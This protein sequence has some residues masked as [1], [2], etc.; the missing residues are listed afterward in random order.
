MTIL[1]TV[2]LQVPDLSAPSPSIRINIGRS[3]I[4][5]GAGCTYEHISQVCRLVEVMFDKTKKKRRGR[6]T[7]YP[8]P[9]P[10]DA[11]PRYL[12]EEIQDYLADRARYGL[13]QNTMDA[14]ANTLKVLLAVA[15]DVPVDQIDHAVIRKF[16]DELRWW[17]ERAG[18]RNDL[19]DLTPTQVMA[20]GR[21]EAR[22]SGPATSSK[23]THLRHLNAFFN[24]LIPRTL[25]FS[26][27]TEFLSGL[28]DD[29]TSKTRFPLSE[30]NIAKVF[31]PDI[32]VPWAKGHAH[33]WWIPMIALYTGAR[34]DEIAQLRTADIVE[35]QG[36]L[37]FGF[38]VFEKE[39]QVPGM[40]AKNFKASSCQRI[41]PIAQPL[42]DAGFT[43]F[44]EEMRARGF[45][46]LFPNLKAGVKAGGNKLN[47]AGYSTGF[48]QQFGT[49]LRAN[50]ELRSGIATHAFRH[51][52][53][54]ALA[55][56]DVSPEIVASITGH[57]DGYAKSGNLGR[58]VRKNQSK[59]R[60]KQVEALAL[61]K[62]GI[63]L[64]AYTPNQFEEM[65]GPNGKQYP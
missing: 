54:S 19:K 60:P 24:A 3:S 42:L 53:S 15:G 26:P 5:F 27:T 65:L 61:F 49:Y 13:K 43:A 11:A 25:K 16:W 62:P 36:S 48:I 20:V 34:V 63:E 44:V 55:D 64:P 10:L 58:Y 22:E 8:E 12:T 40:R 17:P 51:T 28:K 57:Q 29:K 18:S 35:D 39:A 23:K 1:K 7:R 2:S 56:E 52:L 41:I 14:Y 4:E 21:R 30:D 38:T 59:L 50:T 37:C 6:T 46:R 47:G 31:D 9:L 33:R 45:V 32:F